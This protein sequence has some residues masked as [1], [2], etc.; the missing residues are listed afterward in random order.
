VKNP[1]KTHFGPEI[2]K[3]FPNPGKAKMGKP[4]KGPKPIKAP[5]NPQGPKRG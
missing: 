4:K 5:A 1:C 3:K 2:P